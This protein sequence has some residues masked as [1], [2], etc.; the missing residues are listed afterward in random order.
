MGVPPS[1]ATKALLNQGLNVVGRVC[2]SSKYKFANW[3]IKLPKDM[4]KNP[5]SEFRKLSRAAQ[6]FREGYYS[7]EDIKKIQADARLAKEAEKKAKEATK[8][9]KESKTL[10]DKFLSKAK[11]GSLPEKAASAG[12][13]V[14]KAGDTLIKLAPIITALIA[15]GV[16]V[17]VNQIQ[18]WRNDINEEGQQ[19]LGDSISKV[20][21]LMNGQKGRIDR[22]NA[23][24]KKAELENQ[25]V[26]DRI[27][28]LEK[29]QP[30]I[31]DSVADAKKKSN[32]A[33]YE[34]RTGRT[35]MQADIATVKKQSNDALYETRQGRIKVEAEIA[36]VKKQSND[37]LYETRQGRSKTD[38]KIAL[39]QSQ[40]NK[41][42]QG[43]A[44]NFQSKIEVTIGIIQSRLNTSESKIANLEKPK[45]TSQDKI[46]QT[47]Q[48]SVKTVSNNLGSAVTRLGQLEAQ[49]KTVDPKIADLKAF[50][51]K[52]VTGA[53]TPVE[54]KVNENTQK[55]QQV[56]KKFG[57]TVTSIEGVEKGL[58]E[59]YNL[60]F[61]AQAAKWN[62]ELR[63]QNKKIETVTTSVNTTTISG[64]IQGI[65]SDLE[66]VKTTNEQIK[67]NLDKVT[68]NNNQLK[69]DVTKIDTKLKE[70]EKVN[71]QAIPKLDQLLGLMPLMPGRTADAIRP[72]IPTIPQIETASATGTCRAL[73]PGG[74]SRKALDDLSNGINQNTNNQ[75][76]N[77]FDKLNTGAN[78]A[79]LA[80]LKIIDNK[81]GNQIKGGLSGKLV[82]GFKWL[83][84]DRALSI[85]TFAATVQNH[86][87]LSN[88][89]GTTLL[90]AFSNILTL[91]GLKDDQGQAYD[92]ASVINSSIESFVKSIVGAEN[93]TTISEA[94][95]KANR[96]YQ[97]TTNILNSFQNISSTILSAM[98]VIGGNNSK[99]GNALKKAGTVLDNAYGWMN[100]QPKFNRVT[101][102]LEKFQVGASTIQQVTQ[103]PLDIIQATTELQNANTELVKAI[104]EDEPKNKGTES[105]E[106]DK[107][108]GDELVSKIGSR[109]SNI[110]PDDLFNAAD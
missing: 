32:D 69:I 42:S 43:A 106:P 85:L 2:Q 83:Q 23:D 104:K 4:T 88:N 77:L 37:A 89:I 3:N 55:V 11:G 78:V 94:W 47:I 30:A 109:I 38:E 53:V 92:V 19:K 46:I 98:E 33:L 35:K 50:T 96:I 39:I 91:I 54:V 73:Q 31:K 6:F 24:V 86:V 18:G 34:V 87:M 27:Y 48:D 26:R 20:L 99:I 13:T 65:K 17:A 57:V 103:A 93:Y 97:A 66:K 101:Q 52:L 95:A 5:E 51:I 1:P 102:T 15:I 108:K 71:Q 9:A 56:E 59:T 44:N 84:L 90:S 61:E 74:C 105:P 68:T 76:N 79:E 63:Q 72:S 64:Q 8:L 14:A 82:D 7:L 12:G 75:S 81:L 49:M 62:E 16:S 100:P 107:L 80:L 70:Q 36:L 41:F 21:G 25:R 60:T 28:S 10:W 67:T 29:Q 40:I 58:R 45:P 110:L 22:L